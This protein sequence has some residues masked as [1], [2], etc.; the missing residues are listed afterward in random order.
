M[1]CS[2]V[3]RLK[4]G[5]VVVNVLLV[6]RFGDLGPFWDVK[7]WGLAPEGWDLEAQG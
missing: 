3:A 5:D 1:E 6:A 4:E 7:T 2:W